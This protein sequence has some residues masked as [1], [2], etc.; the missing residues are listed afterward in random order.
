MSKSAS[1]LFAVVAAVLMIATAVSLSYNLW[2]ALVFFIL[3]FATIGA[4]FVVKARSRSKRSPQ[5]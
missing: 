2:L 3:T 1:L 5:S 4:G